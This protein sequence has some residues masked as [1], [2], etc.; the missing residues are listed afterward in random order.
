MQPCSPCRPSVEPGSNWR[1]RRMIHV[2][3]GAAAIVADASTVVAWASAS[4]WGHCNDRQMTTWAFLVSFTGIELRIGILHRILSHWRWTVGKTATVVSA[5]FSTTSYLIQ[6]SHKTRKTKRHRRARRSG[7][8]CR[9][10]CLAACWFL[11]ISSLPY[12]LT[13]AKAIL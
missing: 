2:I 10:R 7:Q 9:L 11:G 5:P 1:V 3:L 8:R 13:P 12:H 4:S 6:P